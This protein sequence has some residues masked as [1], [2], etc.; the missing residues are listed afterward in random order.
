MKL[1]AAVLWIIVLWWSVEGVKVSC[2]NFLY[3]SLEAWFVRWWPAERRDHDISIV[4]NRHSILVYSNSVMASPRQT[5]HKIPPPALCNLLLPCR[6]RKRYKLQNWPPIFW[7]VNFSTVNS[8]T[9]ST[10]TIARTRFA[11]PWIHRKLA[12][13]CLV[14]KIGAPMFKME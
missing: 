9:V 8:I 6:L 10:L 3:S 5:S 2:C 13:I 1:D 11:E 14:W 4:W 12:W 7:L